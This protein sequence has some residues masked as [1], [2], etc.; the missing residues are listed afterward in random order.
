M[1]PCEKIEKCQFYNDRMESMPATSAAMKKSYCLEDKQ[2]CARYQV[3]TAGRPVPADL[4]PHM[5]DR[6]RTLLAS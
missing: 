5:A 2:A 3:S 1:G 4:F 6:A